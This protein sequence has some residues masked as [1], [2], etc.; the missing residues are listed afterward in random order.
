MFKLIVL[1]SFSSLSFGAAGEQKPE[2]QVSRHSL[3]PY[4]FKQDEANHSNHW[5]YNLNESDVV[6]RFVEES[7]CA[8]LLHNREYVPTFPTNTVV[9]DNHL[10]VSSITIKLPSFDSIPDNDMASPK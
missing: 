10:V 4:S 1:L 5:G 7:V 8:Q 9:P 6:N 2:D 3:A